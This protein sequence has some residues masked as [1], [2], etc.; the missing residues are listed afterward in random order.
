MP[1]ARPWTGMT[2]LA[3][4]YLERYFGNDEHPY[5]TLELEVGRSLRPE[6]ALLDAGCG[7]G[8]PVLIK[9]RGKARRLIG[10][11]L[12]EFDAPVD[13]V[14]LLNN[15]LG[16][17]DIEDAAVDIVMCRSVMEHIENPDAVYREIYRILKPGGLF[18]FLT[19]NL[20]DYAALIA[21][22]VPNRLHPWIVAKTEGRQEKDVFPVQYRTNT[23][24]AVQ[25]WASAAGFEIVSFRY[26]GQYPGYF[27]FNGFLFLLATVYEKLL[28]RFETLGFLRGWI[29][30][31]L[32]KP[33]S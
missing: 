15:D 33:Q 22:V 5:R 23:R 12:V 25:R 2:K 27:M 29:Y 18:I 6:H 3:E 14:E 16:R 11:D 24:A 19:A 20:W 31:T 4:K 21:K 1:C 8:A 28:R 30:V 32:R 17:I 13:G 7:R 26:L 10:V 9:Y